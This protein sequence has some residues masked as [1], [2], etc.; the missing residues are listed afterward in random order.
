MSSQNPWDVLVDLEPQ[1]QPYQEVQEKFP[2]LA[3]QEGYQQDIEKPWESLSKAPETGFEQAG[4][5]GAQLTQRALEGTFGIPGNLE[6]L[7]RSFLNMAET[8]K[9]YM[10]EDWRKAEPLVSEKSFFP[11]SGEI[12]EHVKQTT[13]GRYEPKNDF[14]RIAGNVVGDWIFRPGGGWMK[15]ATALGAEAAKEITGALGGSENAK[16]LVDIGT[17]FAISRFNAP[18]IRNYWNRQY[19]LASGAIPR[20][21]VVSATRIQPTLDAVRQRVLD[22]GWADWKAPVITQIEALERNIQ[23]GAVSVR[24]IDQAVKDLNRQIYTGNLP[25]QA[26]RNL[27]T[28]AQGGRRLLRQYG[29]DNPRFLEHWR[30]ANSAYAGWAANRAASDFMQRHVQKLTAGAGSSALMSLMIKGADVTAKTIGVIASTYGI[31]KA[32]EFTARVFANPVT[33]RYY[34]NTMRAALQE[35]APQMI[36]NFTK[37]DAELKKEFKDQKGSKT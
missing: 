31:T 36:N 13:G 18:T 2:E 34:M 37:L 4:R 27:Q 16:A 21:A 33:R 8:K 14:E 12:R 19:D 3:P 20:N 25:G 11:T 9:P 24:S 22:G 32:G 23:N 1:K 28:L 29:Q 6:K 5:V 30:N 7:G 15:T 35:N 10:D 26:I 17:S